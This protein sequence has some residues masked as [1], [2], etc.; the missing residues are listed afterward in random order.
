MQVSILKTFKLN[1][2]CL[3]RQP[4]LSAWELVYETWLRCKLFHNVSCHGHIYGNEGWGWSPSKEIML[5]GPIL[6]ALVPAYLM[7][8]PILNNVGLP[9]A[10]KLSPPPPVQSTCP[11]SHT[12]NTAHCSKYIA[13]SKGHHFYYYLFISNCPS[14]IYSLHSLFWNK[15]WKDLITYYPFIRHGPHRKR[16]SNNSSL[17]RERVYRAV[18]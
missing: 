14:I 12:T 7:R 17:P 18:A 16:R 6:P 5:V 10:T 3:W 2:K 9:P 4:Q 8:F 13:H 1:S 15:F 11:T